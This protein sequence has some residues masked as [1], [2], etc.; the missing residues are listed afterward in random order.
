MNTIKT[1]QIKVIARECKCKDGRTFTAYRAV[2]K[3]GT[4]ID[5]RFRRSVTDIPTGNFI[6]TVNK[7]DANISKARE[8]PC[9]WVSSVVSFDPVPRTAA[10]GEELP[11]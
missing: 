10:E 1:Y 4:L 6:M 3:D 8:F 5:C 2:Q 11:F 9:L 7:G